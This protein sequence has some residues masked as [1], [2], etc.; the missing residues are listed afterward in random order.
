MG[1]EDKQ[2]DATPQKLKKAREEGQVIKSKDLTTA[3]V[4]VVLFFALLGMAPLIW[5]ELARLFVLM[6]EQIPN[7]TLEKIGWQYLLVLTIRAFV[8]V[9]LPFVIL[10]A[11]VGA[12]IE[13]VQTGPLVATKAIEPKFDKLNPVKGFKNIFAMRSVIELVKNLVKITVLG[14]VAWMI[15][16]EFL[17][18]L[19]LTGASLNVF[20]LLGVLGA[21]VSKLILLVGIAFLVIGAADYLY[22]RFK[23]LKDQKMSF[24]EMKDEFKNSEGDPM[25]KH[26][27]RQRRM[28][29]LQQKML[30][31][32]PGADVITTNPIHMAVALK[33]NPDNDAPQVVA[34]GTELFAEKIKELARKNG[35]PVV[36]NPTVTRTLYKLVDLDS[37]IPPDMYQAVAEILMFAWKISGKAPPVGS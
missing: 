22:Q 11:V 35:V 10:A 30:D 25:V 24:K 26:A 12:F 34:K 27:I 29:M 33:Y 6:F 3:F 20:A 19:L 16:Q 18:K 4:L 23:F 31:A 8:F 37:P 14:V 32:V 28:Q 17:G 15:F 13:F 21:L 2:F 7:A 9:I 5:D 1:D 36:E